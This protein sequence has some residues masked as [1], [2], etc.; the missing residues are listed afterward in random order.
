[1]KG[2]GKV[3]LAVGI[4]ALMAGGLGGLVPQNQRKVDY[5][6]FLY[7]SGTNRVCTYCD[8]Y[9]DGLHVGYYITCED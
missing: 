7:A 2:A 9:V 5:L 8:V 6:C 1:M 4:L 3:G